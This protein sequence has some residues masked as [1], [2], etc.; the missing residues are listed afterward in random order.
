MKLLLSLALLLLVGL[1]YS[2]VRYIEVYGKKVTLMTL[3]QYRP[4]DAALSQMGMYAALE[5]A[6]VWPWIMFSGRL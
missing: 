5:Y 3:K 2:E 4:E 6:I 1:H